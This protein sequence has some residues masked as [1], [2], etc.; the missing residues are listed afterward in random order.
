MTWLSETIIIG[1][2]TI[3]VMLFVYFQQRVEL[4]ADRSLSISQMSISSD[5]F[6]SLSL[7]ARRLEPKYREAADKYQSNLLGLSNEDD[8]A[9]Q[10]FLNE[11]RENIKEIYFD[12]IDDMDDIRS[13]IGQI[14]IMNEMIFECGEYGDKSSQSWIQKYLAL[15]F[16][17][18]DTL[19][20][21]YVKHY[22]EMFWIIRVGIY[23]DREIWERY[24]DAEE[25]KIHEDGRT[26]I[27]KMEI[28]LK[29]F[30]EHYYKSPVFI[31]REAR[32][33]YL[34]EMHELPSKPIVIR[35]TLCKEIRT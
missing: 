32:N 22:E 31:T 5:A 21:V 20:R 17:D 10:R 33:A 8:E 19:R 30:L 24:S 25:S 2:A 16:C 13:K 14:L 28:I 18:R 9:H 26:S 29:D 4:S 35:P 12:G 3:V 1:I 34:A 23:C 11:Y 15:P 7:L 27:A 6:Q